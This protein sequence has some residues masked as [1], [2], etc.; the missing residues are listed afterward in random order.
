M[1]ASGIR[2]ESAPV[3]RGKRVVTLL[4]WGC[5][6]D[7]VTRSAAG[8]TIT[9][10]HLMTHVVRF[11]CTKIG[12][13]PLHEPIL[14]HRPFFPLQ[15][16]CCVQVLFGYE[17]LIRDKISGKAPQEEGAVL[18]LVDVCRGRGGLSTPVHILLWAS[19]KHHILVR[20]LFNSI[21]CLHNNDHAGLAQSSSGGENIFGHLVHPRGKNTPRPASAKNFA[22]ETS[23][24]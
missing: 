14:G 23:R 17:H 5:E 4:L 15:R 19:F 12:L 18:D 7:P 9:R 3:S 8:P 6:K 20:V 11:I 1:H 24:V 21:V 16:K 13:S 10:T 2:H 22:D